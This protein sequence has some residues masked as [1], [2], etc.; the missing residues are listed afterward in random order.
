MEQIHYGHKKEV[1]RHS[2]L[3]LLTNTLDAISFENHTTEGTQHP[4]QIETGAGRI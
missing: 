4:N 3:E 2:L 1:E